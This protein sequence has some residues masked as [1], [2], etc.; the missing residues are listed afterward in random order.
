MDMSNDDSLNDATAREGRRRRI[1]IS[2]LLSILWLSI[3]LSYLSYRLVVGYWV[4]FTLFAIGGLWALYMLFVV[5]PAIGNST[6]LTNS[7]YDGG[8]AGDYEMTEQDDQHAT[9][10]PTRGNEQNGDYSNNKSVFPFG[11]EETPSRIRQGREITNPRFAPRNG[12]Y[13]VVYTAIVFGK[14]VRSEGSLQLTFTSL[15]NSPMECV[16]WEIQGQCI[17]GQSSPIPLQDGFVNAEGHIYWVVPSSLCGLQSNHANNQKGRGTT[18]VLSLQNVT[19]YRGILDLETWS[20]EDGEFLSITDTRHNHNAA[21]IRDGRYEGRIVRLEHVMDMDSEENS[22]DVSTFNAN[23]D[24]IGE[25]K[26]TNP[27]NMELV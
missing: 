7:S 2:L 15:S 3:I 26:A 23:R 25:T 13:K 11:F 4:S 18:T 27:A 8:Q 21:T 14:Q 24:S 17:F 1:A 12:I 22:S 16:G 6:T 9:L 19:V 20:W 10:V 5:I